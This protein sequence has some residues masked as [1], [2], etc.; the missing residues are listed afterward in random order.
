[1]YYCIACNQLHQLS[2]VP[3]LVV[4]KTGFHIVEIT[5]YPAGV[6]LASEALQQEISSASA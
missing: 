1:M 5:R 6:C 3:A 2:A 4:F